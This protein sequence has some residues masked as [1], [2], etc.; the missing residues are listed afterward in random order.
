DRRYGANERANSTTTTKGTSTAFSIIMA[1]WITLMP[2]VKAQPTLAWFYKDPAG[3]GYPSLWGAVAASLGG[4]ACC[5][6]G[7]DEGSEIGD[8]LFSYDP[9]TNEVDFFDQVPGGP[10]RH[11]I[12]F[13]IGEHA[14][15]GLGDQGGGGPFFSD[16]R[17]LNGNTGSFDQSYT[18][19]GG[20]RSDAVVFT[21]DGKAYIGGG[22]TSGADTDQNDL[23]EWEP[24]TNTWTA[25]ANMPSHISGGAAF[26]VGGKGY[27][28]RNGSTQFWCYDP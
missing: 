18:F 5:G 16:I 13:S 3:N 4:L 10:R 17:R 27:V 25:R 26:A 8:L 28:L 15:V 24:A 12:A 22:T 23:W 11:G 14:Y 19:P 2:A 9:V 7:T 21:I 1:L 20:T 6:T